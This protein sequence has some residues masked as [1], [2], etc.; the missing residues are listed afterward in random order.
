MGSLIFF[1]FTLEM[2]LFSLGLGFVS[3]VGVPTAGVRALI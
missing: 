1:Q 3:S 2:Y